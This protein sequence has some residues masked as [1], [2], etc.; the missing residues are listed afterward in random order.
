MDGSGK[1]KEEVDARERSQSGDGQDLVSA[2]RWEE[3]KRRVKFDGDFVLGHAS[4]R[5]GKSGGKAG[6][7]QE[8][9]SIYVEFEMTTELTVVLWAV[10]IGTETH[11][12]ELVAQRR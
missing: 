2:W 5:K 8:F 4:N 3:R 9:D 7:G 11:R 10:K 1:R 12:S 6:L